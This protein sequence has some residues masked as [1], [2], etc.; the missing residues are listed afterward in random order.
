MYHEA[1]PRNLNFKHTLKLMTV[2]DP[3]KTAKKA[4]LTPWVTDDPQFTIKV[5]NE[6]Q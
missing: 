1:R 2:S 5:D 3:R 4:T 6:L